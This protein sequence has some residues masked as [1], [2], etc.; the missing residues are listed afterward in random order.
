MIVKRYPQCLG[1]SV[2][3]VKKKTEFLVNGMNWPLKAVV[4]NPAVL[5]Y[6]LE[7]RMAPRC[8]VIKALMSKGLI[9]GQRYVMKHDDEQLV[10]ELMTIFTRG[11]TINGVSLT[12]HI[13]QRNV[14][15]K[16]VSS[17]KSTNRGLHFLIIKC[18]R[19]PGLQKLCSMSL[20]LKLVF[21]AYSKHFSSATTMSR[22]SQ[23]FTVFYLVNSL[24]LTTK[25]AE[26]ISKKVIFEDKDNPEFSSENCIY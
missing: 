12:G 16:I 17:T 19:S 2:E 9:Q 11:H 23:N 18:E 13:E 4:S 22:K 24:D 5:G 10:A 25:L 26:T 20:S 7:K 1:L 3:T 14:C 21:S 15:R 6:S 8:N